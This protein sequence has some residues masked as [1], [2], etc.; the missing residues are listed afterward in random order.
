MVKG[1][2]FGQRSVATIGLATPLI[3]GGRRTSEAPFQVLKSSWLSLALVAVIVSGRP[4]SELA[5]AILVGEV[6]VPLGVQYRFKDVASALPPPGRLPVEDAHDREHGAETYC[7]S[8]R[9]L[10]G[11]S[12]LELFYSD[13]G[14]HTG[15][16]SRVATSE[17]ACTQLESDPTFLVGEWEYSL[18][19]KT[20]SAPLEF[21]SREEGDTKIFEREWT[22]TDPSRPHKLGTCFSRGVYIRIERERGATR[23]IT[24]QNWEEPGC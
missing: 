6:R 3:P 23:S 18:S 16:I 5:V 15:R 12:R 8:Y 22:Y 17:T 1:A 20:L 13:F 9:T 21:T 2:T 19:S 7:Y 24:V 14:L 10:H 11:V 4:S